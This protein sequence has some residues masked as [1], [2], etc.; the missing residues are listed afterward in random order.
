MDTLLLPALD[1]DDL[2]LVQRWFG[3]ALLGENL[4]QRIL[5]LTGTPGGGKGALVRVVCGIIGLE[6]LASLR[7]GLLAERFELSRFLGRTL[8]L[9]GPDVPS[10]FLNQRSASV[11]KALTWR[12]SF[13]RGIQEFQRSARAHL[14]LQCYHHVKLT[15]DSSSGGRH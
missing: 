10:D 9:Y 1:Q 8:L 4:A 11:L 13:Y 14:P 12:R 7:T 5:L 3:L 15:A 2:N 6:N